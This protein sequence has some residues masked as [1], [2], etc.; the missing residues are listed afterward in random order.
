M[1]AVESDRVANSDAEG[2]GE[3][4]LDHHPTGAD[5]AAGGEHRLVERCGCWVAAFDHGAGREPTGFEEGE[6]DRV[7][8]AGGDDPRGALQGCQL[9]R[10]GVGGDRAARRDI[11]GQVGHRVGAGG[12]SPGGVVGVVGLAVQVPTPT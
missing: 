3:A 1:T 5:P 6:G 4:A 10:V 7:R 8:P 12:D 11:R 2:V 9:V